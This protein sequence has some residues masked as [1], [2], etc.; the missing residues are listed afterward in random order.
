MSLCVGQKVRSERWDQAIITNMICRKEMIDHLL[1]EMML[2]ID[3]GRECCRPSYGE[4]KG[5]LGL[6]LFGG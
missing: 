4:R 5:L 1:V 6:S 3:D 2:G